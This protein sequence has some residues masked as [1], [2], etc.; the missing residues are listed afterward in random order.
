MITI[1]IPRRKISPGEKLVVLSYK[2]YNNIIHR[3]KEILKALKIIAKGEKE[4]REGKT[5]AASSLK[6]ALKIHAKR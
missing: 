5:I 1:T 3:N 4:F 6:E 2:E